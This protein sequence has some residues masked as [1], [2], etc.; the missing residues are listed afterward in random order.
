[1][2][3]RLAVVHLVWGPLGPAPLAAFLDAYAARDAGEEH[4][5]VVLFNGVQ[6]R[7]PLLELIAGVEHTLLELERPVLDLAAYFEAA[8]SLQHARLCFL[9]SYS[10]PLADGW[11]SMLDRALSGARMAAASGSWASHSDHVRYLLGLGGPYAG[12]YGA[13]TAAASAFQPHGEQQPQAPAPVQQAASRWRKPP[14]EL[15]RAA[16]LAMRQ[17]TG[18]PGFPNPH[19]RTNGFIVERETMLGL[20]R[21]R[22]ADKTDTYALESGRRSLTR[23]LNSQVAL[24]GRD[25]RAYTPSEWAHSNT[26]W[27]AAQE[28]LLIADNQTRA[29]VEGDAEQRRMLAAHAWGDQARPS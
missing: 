21:G 5:L 25:G 11:L 9:N 20:K 26:F 4:E 23:Q 28:N 16:A 6:E 1:M 22:I 15:F 10:E 17:L 3:A 8:R 2:S 27:Q 7:E 12:P 14:G 24:V 18:F 13:R 19:L 29:Y